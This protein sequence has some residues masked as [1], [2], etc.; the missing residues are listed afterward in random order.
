MIPSPCRGFT[1]LF[2]VRLQ[3]HSRPSLRPRIRI[4]GQ[5]S[6]QTLPCS[7]HHRLMEGWLLTRHP[8]RLGTTF[9]GDRRTVSVKKSDGHYLGQC[10]P[11]QQPL[12]HD[13]LG[14]CSQWKPDHCG[15]TRQAQGGWLAT[16]SFCVSHYEQGTSSSQKQE[17]LFGQYGIN[18][19]ALP[20]RFR[21][22]S[23]L[24]RQEAT[25]SVETPAAGGG[26]TPNRESIAV[27]S[28]APPRRSR[29]ET[30]VEHCDIIGPAFWS[31][32]RSILGEQPSPE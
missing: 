12:Q 10:S 16:H 5:S 6:S 14:P 23:V 25:S 18:Y 22:G 28:P 15:G 9:R 26:D 32:R 3:V 13:V 20:E 19:N 24:Y 30:V 8:W 1:L 21:K 29:R 11:H 4:D 17:I 27:S 2:T 7:I 31:S